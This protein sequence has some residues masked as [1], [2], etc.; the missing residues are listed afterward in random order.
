MSE[1]YPIALPDVAHR[2]TFG[3]ADGRLAAL[4]GTPGDSMT[5]RRVAILLPG[6]TGSKEDFI[7]LLQPIAAAGYHVISYDQR[8]QYESIGPG[9][10]RA[11]SIA[12][13]ARDL[14]DVIGVISKGEPVHLVGH[15]FGGLVARNLVIAEPTLVRSL[16]LL[17]S[18]PGGASLLRARWL[19]PLIGL[20][21][22]CGSRP[23]ANLVAQAARRTGVSP[24]RLP[25]LRYRLLHT[26]R[27]GLVGMCLALSREPDR[28]DELASTS[29]PVLVI[30][31]ENDDAWSPRVQ[32]DMAR[33]LNAPFVIIKNAGH[34]PNEDQPRPTADA[35]IKF[36]DSMDTGP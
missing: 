19:G 36:W 9:C 29:V 20:I 17:D 24:D 27:V 23:L 35:I 31:G 8:G 21:R 26:Q 12:L 33:R 22:L 32:E 13:F 3:T 15:S 7:P 14:R 16:T 18:G 4:E 5:A 25:W 28:V 10:E 1:S 11:Y 2:R 6:F 34:T 30:S